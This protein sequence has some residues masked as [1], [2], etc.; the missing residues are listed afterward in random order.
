MKANRRTPDLWLQVRYCF[1]VIMEVSVVIVN[2]RT[3]E[4]LRECLR[5][6]QSQ[7]QVNGLEI[8]VVD[9]ASGD[10]STE[11]IAEVFPQVQTIHNSQNR[12]FATAC[13]QGMRVA[14]GRFIMLLNPDTLVP[15]LTIAKLLSFAKA[16]A[17]SAVVGCRVAK[18]DG[19]L[20][21]TCFRYPSLLNVALSG[22]CLNK[23]LPKSRFFGREFMTW[24]NRDSVRD[25]DVITGS[26]M[27]VRREAIKQVG[28][29]DERYFIYAEEADWC[30]RFAQAG[31]RITFTPTA[32]IVHLSSQSSSQCWPKM[33]VWQRKSILL[34][35][36]K[37]H[38]SLAR[39]LANITLFLTTLPRISFW[40]PARWL[41]FA[42]DKARQ[43]SEAMLAALRF[44]L[45]GAVPE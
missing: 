8:I 25:V 34:F 7:Q 19:S 9:N 20:E 45:T 26:C 36:E 13:N 30:R 14:Q 18:P 33:Y 39:R 12:G 40:L 28:L 23:L 31:W 27:L 22:L 3:R 2:W 41:G 35:L 16:N 29:M 15:P 37:W 5:S 43:Q 44:H 42:G 24:W 38:G 21:P 17:D 10:G 11:M 4:A 1:D 6:L 32:E